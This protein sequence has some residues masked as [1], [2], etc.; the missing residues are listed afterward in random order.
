MAKSHPGVI[1]GTNY[2]YSPI[3]RAIFWSP[4]SG[5]SLSQLNVTPGYLSCHRTSSRRWTCFRILLP[6]QRYISPWIS[7]LE[8]FNSSTTTRC[9]TVAKVML[10]T[11]M[12]RA[13]DTCCV[14][15]SPLKTGGICP[16]A[17]GSDTPVE[18]YQ[19]DRREFHSSTPC[20]KHR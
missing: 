16:L 6:I 17:F 4:L 18:R 5:D 10:T 1:R 9:C 7:S 11:Q 19:V 3:T 15:G 12:H 2:P 20:L 8:T 14:F 13:S